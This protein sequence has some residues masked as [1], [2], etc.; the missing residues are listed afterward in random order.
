MKTDN[1]REFW[2]DA[3]EDNDCFIYNV[4]RGVCNYN[5]DGA[6]RVIEHTAVEQ[7]EQK[8]K[9]LEKAENAAKTEMIIKDLRKAFLDLQ[10]TLRAPS[11]S[12]HIRQAVRELGERIGYGCLMSAAQYEWREKLK[13]QGLEGGEFAVGHCVAV[14][15][16]EIKQLKKTGALK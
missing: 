9:S 2:I 3:R 12:L 5:F 11:E 8:V 4:K 13:E 6:I 15:E 1:A 7:L 10:P 14:Y 16:N